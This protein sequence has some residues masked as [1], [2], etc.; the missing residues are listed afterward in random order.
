MFKFKFPLCIDYFSE[1]GK[2]L[3][4]PDVFWMLDAWF[5]VTYSKKQDKMAVHSILDFSV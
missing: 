3:I 5:K 2:N 1:S 4:I